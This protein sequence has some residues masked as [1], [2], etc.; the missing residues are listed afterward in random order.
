MNFDTTGAEPLGM[1][2]G[3]FRINTFITDAVV[4]R[5]IVAL[6]GTY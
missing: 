3:A 5:A 4:V 6:R 2:A 1:P